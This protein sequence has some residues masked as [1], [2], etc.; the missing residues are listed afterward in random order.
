M[1]IEFELLSVVPYQA[2]GQFGHRFTLRIALHERDGARLNWIERTDRPYV[3]GM[4][5]DTWTD[6][7]QLSH[8]QSMVFT[9]WNQT[10]GESGEVTVT[11]IDPPS[12]RM[13]PYAQRTLQF[14]IV[15]LDGEGEDWAVW[16]G[17]QTLSCS[18]TGA[19]VTQTLVQTANT[20]GD[21]GD[22]PYP[23][24]FAPY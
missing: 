12:M 16:E 8:G 21:D 4:Q 13:E 24:G 22:P 1:A 6:M 9:D 18:D 10:A 7:F 5:P 3:P 14:W 17:T 23:E 11:F 20:N 19:I 2:D 15:V